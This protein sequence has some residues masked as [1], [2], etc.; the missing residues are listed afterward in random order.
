MPTVSL[1]PF[2]PSSD[3]PVLAALLRQAHVVRWWGD[4]EEA[5]A[6]IRAHPAATEAL[7][8]VDS[9]P[10]GFVCWQ[11]LSSDELASAGLSDLPADTIDVDIMIGDPDLL[12]RG[13]G[14]AALALLLARLR[15]ERV[16][17][18]GIATAVTNTRALRAFQKAGF[19]PY[20]DFH[21]AGQQWRYLVQRLD[22]AA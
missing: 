20:R 17:M 4:P 6:A 14:P 11:P 22:A 1:A 2:E 13:V 15:A 5:L 18:V 8:E 16:G 10:V 12:G 19:R 7:I 9:A 21:E 3:L